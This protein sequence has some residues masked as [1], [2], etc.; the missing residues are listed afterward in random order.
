MF[1]KQQLPPKV[2]KEKGFKILDFLNKQWQNKT[3]CEY[4]QNQSFSNLYEWKNEGTTLF[5][6]TKYGG[7]EKPSVSI[8]FYHYVLCIVMITNL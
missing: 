2:W 4:Q 1:E 8:L 6:K 7:L 5:C 3:Q